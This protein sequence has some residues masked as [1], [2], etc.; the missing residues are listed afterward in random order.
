[1]KLLYVRMANGSKNKVIQ[2][3]ALPHQDIKKYNLAFKNDLKNFPNFSGS[4]LVIGNFA[5]KPKL[6]VTMG[7]RPPNG[8]S[9]N[10]IAANR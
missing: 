7:T 4:Q 8:V 3:Y 5:W 1:M 10:A 2:I 9:Q 6:I